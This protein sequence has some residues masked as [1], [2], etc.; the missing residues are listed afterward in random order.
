MGIQT[1][2]GVTLALIE[3]GRR[4][5][6]EAVGADRQQP[7]AVCRRD[8]D[9]VLVP[10]RPRVARHADPGELQTESS[11]RFHPL[12]CSLF[13]A[14]GIEILCSILELFS[15]TPFFSCRR[16]RL[17]KN[18]LGVPGYRAEKGGHFLGKAEACLA[19]ATV[20]Q[21]HHLP[22]ERYAIG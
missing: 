19:V 16:V 11:V 3:A 9:R 1:P 6:I 4:G 10:V 20:M 12:S 13:Q 17:T 15:V 22:I 14:A 8:I 21:A 2:L 7:L 5:D 18:R